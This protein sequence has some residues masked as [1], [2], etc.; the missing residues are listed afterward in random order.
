MWAVGPLDG[1]KDYHYLERVVLYGS[2]WP[3]I[4]LLSEA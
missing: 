4:V 3:F 2:S 1:W